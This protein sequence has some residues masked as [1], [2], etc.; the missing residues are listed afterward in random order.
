MFYTKIE[1]T[2]LDFFIKT[3]GK[4]NVLTGNKVL[5]YS[6]DHTEDL[7]YKPEVVLFPNSTELVSKIVS[8]CN[9]NLIPITPSA[10]LTG[11]SGG[12][13]PYYKGVSLSM[14]KM[15]QIYQY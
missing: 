15:N 10:A 3:L 13:L 12:A 2:H 6:S 8:F 9:S 4:E 14:K 11:L 1:A 7:I 5:E